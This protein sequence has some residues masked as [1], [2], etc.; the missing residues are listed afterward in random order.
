V[1]RPGFYEPLK[2]FLFVRHRGQPPVLVWP[3][4]AVQI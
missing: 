1:P 2:V 4:G 3:K